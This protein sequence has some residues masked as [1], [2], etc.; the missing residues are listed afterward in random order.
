MADQNKIQLVIEALNKTQGAFDDLKRQISGIGG[1][2]QSANQQSN[3]ALSTMKQNWLAI[4]AAVAAAA[5]AINKAFD[6][7]EEGAK[8]QQAEESF[9]AVAKGAGESADE[10]LEAMKRASNG[11]IDD[12]DIMQKAV[13]GMLQGLSLDQL[14]KIMEA[15]R[16]AARVTGQ[17]VLQAYE[18]ITEA[19]TNKQ[20]R[21][22]LQYGLVSREQAKLLEANLAA[23]IRTV[24]LYTVAMANAAQQLE[25]FGGVQENNSEKVQHWKTVFKEIKET[26]GKIIMDLVSSL[27]DSLGTWFAENP[28]TIRNWAATLVE[29]FTTIQAEFIRFSMLLDKIGGTMTSAGMLLFGPG[30]ALG[31]E[32][33]KK[34]FERLAQA[35]LDY[36]ARYNE[37][38]KMLQDLAGGLDARL[39]SIRTPATPETKTKS[40][41]PGTRSIS[42]EQEEINR[43][44]RESQRIKEKE[45]QIQMQIA[46]LDIGEKERS[47]SHID[48]AQKRIELTEKLLDTQIAY[49]EQIDKEANPAAWAQQQTAINQ[50]KKQLSDFRLALRELNGTFDQGISEGLAR[51]LDSVGSVFQNAVKLA[52][53]A[54]RAME[55]AFSDFFFDVFSANLKSFKDYMQSFLNSIGKAVSE[56]LSKL[57]VAGLIKGI[58]SLFSGGDSGTTMAGSFTTTAHSG[59]YI[60]HAGGFVPRLHIG[61]NLAPD[62]RSAI[63]QTGEYVVS[64]KGVAALDKINSGQTGGGNMNVVVNV[65]NQTGQNMDAKQTGA[66][67]DGEKYIVSVVLKSADSFGPLYHLFK[68]GK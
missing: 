31:N 11:T 17:D 40:Q 18:T 8:A 23:G 37:K 59:G 29:I 42:K 28:K 7:M 52:E 25:I 3:S 47:I 45:A 43:Q 58:G 34:Q 67:F 19:I 53:D 54:A 1:A 24:D 57:A 38:D 41:S 65:D 49:G 50:T 64:R 4:T 30:A 27:D 68:S 66:Q 10:I 33:S 12:S 16:I 44:L 32:N 2:T 35:N 62:E 6:Y 36:E 60:M 51:Y 21:A 39:E 48:A 14:V 61:G 55:S 56:Y 15:A 13:K 5:V 26:I 9:R 22:L 63:L 20:P 46:N